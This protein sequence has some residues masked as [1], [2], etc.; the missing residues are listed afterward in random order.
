M[1]VLPIYSFVYTYFSFTFFLLRDEV[2]EA[3]SLQRSQFEMARGKRERVWKACDLLLLLLYCHIPLGRGLEFR[4]LEV[5]HDAELPQPFAAA[6][7]HNRNIALLQK[8]CGLTIPTRALEGHHR[9]RGTLVL[10]GTRYRISN[11]LPCS[12][13]VQ[14]VT[15][16]FSPFPPPSFRAL[17]MISDRGQTNSEKNL[18]IKSMFGK[19]VKIKAEYFPSSG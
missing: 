3:R 13:E 18:N 7:F 15:I 10:P 19:V 16:P 5:V 9:S 6:R 11:H 2:L 1:H 12:G 14:T 17:H 4:T 8:D